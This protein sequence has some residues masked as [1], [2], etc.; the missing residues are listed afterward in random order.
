M[1][2]S[3]LAPFSKASHHLIFHLVLIF[4]SQYVQNAKAET[5]ASEIGEEDDTEA[6]TSEAEESPQSSLSLM[7]LT[8]DSEQDG[9]SGSISHVETNEEAP[10][11]GKAISDER[12]VSSC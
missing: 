3:L 10:V 5:G 8:V 12:L 7:R 1:Y 2:S 4:P 9:Q 6:D 11:S